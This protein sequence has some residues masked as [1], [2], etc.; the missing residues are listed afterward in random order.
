MA[1]AWDSWSG[2]ASVV[3]KGQESVCMECWSVKRENV[4]R[5]GLCLVP[6]RPGPR[7]HDQVASS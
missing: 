4:V 6:E 5:G 7:T 3:G 2:S 1:C